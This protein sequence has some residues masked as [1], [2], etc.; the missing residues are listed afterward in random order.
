MAQRDLGA[1]AQVVHRPVGAHHLAGVEEPGGVPEVLEGRERADEL[2]AVHLDQQLGA[3]LAVAVLARERA[4]VRHDEVCGPVEEGAP[5]GD[6][7]GRVEAEVDPAVDAALPEVAVERRVVVELGEQVAEV[8]EVAA[9]LVGCH[10]RVLP[11]GV[12]RGLARH[13]GRGAQ[14]RLADLPELLLLPAVLEELDRR[15]V[16]EL[17]H[18]VD[19]A[20]RLVVRFLFGVSAELDEQESLALGQQVDVV[21]VQA[22]GAHVVDQLGV[23]AFEP[24]RSVLADHRHVVAGGVDVGVAEHDQGSG[25]S[26]LDE[27]HGGV[28][29]DD[30]GS[31]GTDE[32]LGHVE[33]ALGEEP[34]QVEA[35]HAPGDV[36]V[37]GADGVLVVVAQ[38]TQA[39]VDLAFAVA[40]RDRW[41]RAPRATSRRPS[42]G[43]RP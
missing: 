11:P 31:L 4:A 23:E 35:R 26:V 25:G 30:A 28:Q 2:L 14:P 36:G 10:R 39:A 37:P 7:M 15:R 17:L 27:L 20:R 34:I 1:G 32:R 8:P 12:G 13:L 42:C 21:G 33:A 9:D 38:V 22:L 41:P 3:G 19:E 29:D 6:S 16:V 5:L 43:D 40:P 24:D 18:R